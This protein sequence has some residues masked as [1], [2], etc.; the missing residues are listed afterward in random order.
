MSVSVMTPKDLVEEGGRIASE[1]DKARISDALNVKM[2]QQKPSPEKPIKYNDISKEGRSEERPLA[3]D[4]EPKAKKAL[5]GV[6]EAKTNA[7]TQNIQGKGSDGIE[8]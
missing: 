2:Q 1:G 7:P 8:R 4:K 6:E 5:K 3:V